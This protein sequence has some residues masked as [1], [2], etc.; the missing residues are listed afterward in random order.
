MG[1]EK[2]LDVLQGLLV[3]ILWSNGLAFERPQLNILLGLALA[4]AIEL[5]LFTA[6][7]SF[8]SHEQFLPEMKCIIDCNRSWVRWTETSKEEKRAVLG[9]LYLFSFASVKFSCWN[10]LQWTP[11][12][13]QCHKDILEDP[14][15]DADIY[16]AHLLGLQRI[17][18]TIKNV[19][20]QS[21]ALDPSSRRTS[22]AIHVKLLTS[23]LQKFMAAL[24]D[25]LKQDSLML[26]HY[27]VVETRLFD[28]GFLMPPTNLVHGPTPQRAD[29]LLLCLSACQKLIKSLLRLDCETIAHFSTSNA[30]NISVAMSILSKLMLFHA[31]D[32][33]I[34]NVPLEMDL[35]TFISW[36]VALLEDGSSRYD[37][38]GSSKQPWLQLSRKI[39]LVGVRFDGLMTIE[40]NR[41]FSQTVDQTR[42]ESMATPLDLNTF[43]LF[44]D[45]FWQLLPVG[46]PLQ[47]K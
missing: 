5:S 19:S 12:I 33:D 14:D 10:P 21:L 45:A 32:W 7:C 40:N 18:D 13:Q 25:K 17:A 29:L 36:A 3:Y 43:D 9:C 24:P 41:L 11:Y 44:D 22:V 27:H 31:E 20:M 30:A 2:N 47:S 34:S 4:L 38:V 1:G 23:E 35:P 8:E 26:V 46:P 16:L 42:D 6:P 39:K 28:L 15:S 37:R